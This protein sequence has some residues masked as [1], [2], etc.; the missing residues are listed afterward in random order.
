[1][2]ALKSSARIIGA[3]S[4]GEKAQLLE[5]AGKEGDEAYIRE[6][7]EGFVQTCLGFKEPLSKVF[8]EES[9]EKIPADAELVEAVY[10]EIKAAAE[11]MDCDTLGSIVTE[12]DAYEM[13][14]EELWNHIKEATEKY[15][16]AGLIELLKDK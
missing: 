9:A 15:D 2:H 3:A 5:N 14:D 10:S 12:M 16:Y 7:H 1:M 6:H 8:Q 11:D 13:P 4:F